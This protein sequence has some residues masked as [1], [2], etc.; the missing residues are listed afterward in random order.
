MVKVVIDGTSFGSITING[1]CYEHDVVITLG[2]E[3]LKRNK[4]PAKKKYGTSHKIPLEEAEA[5]FEEGCK[6]LII[7][8]G[9]NDS[10]RLSKKAK[11]FFEEGKVKVMLQSTP[12][13]IK[14]FNAAG[15]KM[16]GLFHV[17]C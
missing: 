12:E 17:T 5:I 11:R 1:Q 10:V 7:G 13:A 3:I 2:G 8:T 16:V 9:Q 4:K 6:Q 14:A 15:E